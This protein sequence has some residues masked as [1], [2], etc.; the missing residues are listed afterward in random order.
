MLGLL[1][2]LVLTYGVAL[3]WNP[4]SYEATLPLL[5][6]GGIGGAILGVMIGRRPARPAP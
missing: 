4:S 1:V 3:L 2:G 6:A 5:L